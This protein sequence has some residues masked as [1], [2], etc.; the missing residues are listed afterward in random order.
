[1]LHDVHIIRFYG[2][3]TDGD[4]QYLFLE[5]ASGGELFDKIG[6][7]V[8]PIILFYIFAV[9]S[10]HRVVIKILMLLILPNVWTTLYNST[11]DSMCMQN[12]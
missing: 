3:R 9:H 12:L 8:G 5:Y 4:K 11:G 6:K 7:V 10:C 1:M 2:S